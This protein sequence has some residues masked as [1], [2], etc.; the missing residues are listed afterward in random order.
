MVASES[1]RSIAYG[2]STASGPA[3]RSYLIDEKSTITGTSGAW[4]GFA[5][6][7]G[8]P[9]ATAEA[10][11][12]RCLWDF[13][14]GV[15][16]KAFLNTVLF[17]CRAEGR[18]FTTTYRCDSPAERRLCRMTV[19]PRGDLL[20]VHHEAV[21]ITSP[22]RPPNVIAPSFAKIN[23]CSMCCSVNIEGEWIDTFALPPLCDFPKS[24]SLCPPCKQEIRRALRPASQRT[25]SLRA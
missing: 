3:V 21:E 13:V 16:T 14:A 18:S 19:V 5:L 23:R 6:E 2:T 15:E 10:V 8:A 25:V 7:N 22:R 1:E 12:G 9:A 24:Y 17:I 4:D 11:V 20:T